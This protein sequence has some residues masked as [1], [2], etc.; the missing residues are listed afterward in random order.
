MLVQSFA[1][2]LIFKFRQIFL[3]KQDTR[4]RT[5]SNAMYTQLHNATQGYV[6]NRITNI[7][8]TKTQYNIIDTQRQDMHIEC[9]KLPITVKGANAPLPLLL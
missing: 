5:G 1:L 3:G 9:S 6:I 8:D 4:E 7:N 2:T